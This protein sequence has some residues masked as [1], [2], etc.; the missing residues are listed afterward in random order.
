MTKISTVFR[1]VLLTSL[2]LVL[3]ACATATLPTIPSEEQTTSNTD[4]WQRVQES[5]KLI[6]GT[7]VDYPPFEYY[8]QNFIVDGFDVA[9]MRQI[10]KELGLQ[11][12][13]KDI[14]FDGLAAAL[15]VNQID[16]AI[17]AMSI[18][19]EREQTIDF[20]QIYYVSE[21]AVLAANAS[22][23]AIRSYGDLAGYTIGV[24]KGSVFAEILKDQL[25]STGLMRP[26]DLFVYGTTERAVADLQKGLVD[27]VLLDLRPAQSLARQGNL[28]LVGQGLTR[29]R[30]A[31][32][33]PKGAATL[34]SEI[35][36]ALTRLRER[37]VLVDLAQR[38]LDLAQHEMQP[39]P[40]AVLPTPT[41]SAP[42]T[43]TPTPTQAPAAPPSVCTDVM[44]YVADLTYDDFNMTQPPVFT[45]GQ[46]FRKGWRIRNSGSC[47]WNTG[48]SLTFVDG[49]AP[50]ASMGGRATAING[51]V[52]PGATYDVYAD[53]VAPLAPGVYR[54]TWQMRNAQGTAFG[55]RVWVGISVPGRP[56]PT[57]A[58]TQTPSP[59]ISFSV[60]RNSIRAGDCVV[61]QWNATNVR[62]VYFYAEGQ[63]W[64]NNG[65]AGQDSRRLCLDR[66]TNYYLQVVRQD[67]TVETKQIPIN[68]QNVANSP[69]IAR[70]TIDPSPQIA[71]GQCVNLHWDVQGN[72]QRVR[73]LRNNQTL[74]EEAPYS[75]NTQDCPSAGGVDYTLEAS[76]PGGTNRASNHIEVVV[77]PAATATP[78]P[79]AVPAPE[80]YSFF[81]NPTQITTGQCVSLAWSTGGSVDRTRLSRNGAV[82]LDN[83]PVNSSGLQDCLDQPGVTT[84]VLE[85]HG[86]GGQSALAQVSVNVAVP[87]QPTPTPQPQAPVINSFNI[88]RTTITLGECI[89]LSWQFGGD[90]LAAAQ[91]F[92]NDEVIADDMPLSGSQQDCPPTPGNYAYQLKVDSE[93]G[94]I[95]QQFQYLTVE[96]V[97]AD[98]GEA[99]QLPETPPVIDS[100]T[101]D[102]TQIDLGGCVNLAWIFSGTSLVG[103]RLLRNDAEIVSEALT[104]GEFQDCIADDSLVGAVTYRLVVDSEFSGST[105]AE[106]YVTVVGG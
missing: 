48:Y 5:G 90:S 79:T 95:A 14:A 69:T 84:Y 104:P 13:F 37:G 76:G 91:I 105:S 44:A 25:I 83:G 77:Q 87:E 92:R 45:P 55:E 46:L 12:E 96:D 71:V 33:V 8:N 16:A 24:Q 61:F 1:T 78:G 100:F 54:G 73:L 68:V 60:D 64:Q 28:A 65:V 36:E 47:T 11:V 74:W 72:I 18:T 21:D 40:T 58:P 7:S 52:P 39:I 63:N 88:D 6:V 99:A 82:I 20:S 98:A 102:V 80:I 94:G 57:A 86:Q 81:L 32:A 29:E 67:N 75:G 89:N 101:V 50:A 22:M 4:A 3:T 17:A 9:L 85:A 38:Y 66:T 10:G 2:V 53:L 41:A 103:A 30:Y 56:A 42:A 31:I 26:T 51:P 93:F 15:A 34:R 19:P 59:N 70:F 97:A 43:V 35:N 49:N 62:A 106:Q 23:P 27:L